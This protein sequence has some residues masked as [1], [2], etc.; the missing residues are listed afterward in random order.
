MLSVL[1]NQGN[2]Q[3]NTPALQVIS[4]NLPGGPASALSGSAVLTKQCVFPASCWGRQVINTSTRAVGFRPAST[5]LM[6]NWVT[7][8]KRRRFGCWLSIS[9][10][11]FDLSP[12][13]RCR[14]GGGRWLK[15]LFT[16]LC[17]DPCIDGRN[18]GPTPTEAI[19]LIFS[20]SEKEADAANPKPVGL[21]HQNEDQQEGRYYIWF[22]YSAPDLCLIIAFLMLMTFLT[23]SD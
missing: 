14:G 7:C 20:K 21:W 12:I 1:T 2:S 19:S 16:L 15:S 13:W 23:F 4:R 10:F 9:A 17:C 6:G 5:P 8:I 11:H 22:G 18:C 3:Q